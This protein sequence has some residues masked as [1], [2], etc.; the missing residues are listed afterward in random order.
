MCSATEVTR[1]GG[2]PSR[3]AIF[4]PNWIVTLCGLTL[5]SRPAFSGN[6]ERFR[7][8]SD[9]A[10]SSSSAGETLRF[11]DWRELVG[12]VWIRPEL[13]DLPLRPRARL[14]RLSR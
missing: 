2:S 11:P 1:R 10:K 8:A 6:P 3:V 7:W 14:S 5:D 9:F 13:R 12:S 4:L